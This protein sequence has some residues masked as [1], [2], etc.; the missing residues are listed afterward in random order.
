MYKRGVEAV[1]LDKSGL[2]WTD[3]VIEESI[4]GSYK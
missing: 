2:F 1:V 4:V 3:P